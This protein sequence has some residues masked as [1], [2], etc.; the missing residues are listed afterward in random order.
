MVNRYS[1]GDGQ[2]QRGRTEEEI[3]LVCFFHVHVLMHGVSTYV[4]DC[5]AFNLSLP[6]W[7]RRS[8]QMWII[9]RWGPMLC[10]EHANA[11]VLRGQPLS[12]LMLFL[13]SSF[14]PS[15]LP[16]LLSLSSLFLC[17]ITPLPPL[18]S[19]PLL[20]LPL[21]LFLTHI[22]TWTMS[23][24]HKEPSDF[25]STPAPAPFSHWRCVEHVGV[26]G[27]NKTAFR[28]C[29]LTARPN[30]EQTAVSFMGLIRVDSKKHVL[31]MRVWKWFTC[32]PQVILAPLL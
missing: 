28:H 23:W 31:K 19:P 1:P 29:W 8:Y 13:Y 30:I 14:V 24:Q 6:I 16:L 12:L 9:L 17:P 20:Q 5:W 7:L 15:I 27:F 4:T 21:S 18:P 32:H 3:T 2:A 11:R 10:S 26:V 25:V 22:M